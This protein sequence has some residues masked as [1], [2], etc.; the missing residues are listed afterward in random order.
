M[1]SVEHLKNAPIKEALIDLRIGPT[2]KDNALNEIESLADSI[3]NSYPTKKTIKENILGFKLIP[4]K[5][6]VHSSSKSELGY[7]CENE[8]RVV[9]FR[10]DGF[11]FS[12]LTPYSNW[13]TIRDEAKSLWLKYI[14][15]VSPKQVTRIAVRYIN[16]IKLPRTGK[17]FSEYFD[18][19]PTVPVA[20]NL[21]VKNFLNRVQFKDIDNNID[22]IL[23]HSLEGGDSNHA[24]VTLD[25]DAFIPKAFEI[26]D[27]TYW[28]LFE[29]LHDFK[30][31]IF[32][33]CITEKTKELYK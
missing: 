23:T 7:R 26:N 14:K 32:F 25:I 30:N 22:C 24:F 15:A 5:E 3:S 2:I 27:E 20:P 10:I 1:A 8:N 12:E 21:V 33:T 17:D 29:T 19:S 6:L 28:N 31:R 4:D 16:L 13:V 18:I 9:Q 11:T